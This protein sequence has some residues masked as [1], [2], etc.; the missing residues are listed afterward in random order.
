MQGKNSIFT[1]QKKCF[2]DLVD[3]VRNKFMKQDN[4]QPGPDSSNY[5]PKL[6]VLINA[7]GVV[8]AGD[9]ESSFPQD[10]DYIMDINTRAPFAL[11]NFF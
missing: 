8:F 4:I 6:D 5:N 7:A 10:H 3:A 1:N 11:I 2:Q 9:L